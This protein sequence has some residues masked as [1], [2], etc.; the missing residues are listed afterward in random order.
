MLELTSPTVTHDLTR[1]SA[2]P[3]FVA[4]NTAL[5]VGLDGSVNVERVGGRSV[6]TIGG[7]SDFCVGAA[8]SPGGLAVI[9][10]RST[11]ARDESTILPQVDVVTKQRSDIDVVVTEHRERLRSELG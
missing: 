11:T 7:H 1:L 3:R 4:C 9:A 8:R 2:I 6:A 5:Q 10:L